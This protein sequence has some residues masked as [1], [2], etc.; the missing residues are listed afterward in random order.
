[1]SRCAVATP[2]EPADVPGRPTGVRLAPVLLLVMTTACGVGP[3]TEQA[4]RS[5]VTPAAANEG[6]GALPCPP[7]SAVGP[8]SAIID[9][10][11]FV[12][13][14]GVMYESSSNGKLPAT[15]EIGPAFAT[16]C[17]TVSTLDGTVEPQDGDAAYLPAGTELHE[18]IGHDRRT[19][20]AAESDG[21]MVAFEA[22]HNPKAN[23]GRE[24]LD[25]SS[26]LAHVRILDGVNGTD[27]VGELT[28]AMA[29]ADLAERIMA[30]KVDQ[31]GTYPHEDPDRWFV[32]LTTGDGLTTRRAFWRSTGELWRGI[33]LDADAVSL[34]EGAARPA[35]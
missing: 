24:L 9:Y 34:L 12:Q 29:L 22:H 21:R 33:L 2:R 20:L 27:P 5:D 8:T 23:V 18:L 6:G 7:P 4:A 10:V 35:R 32:E 26:G 1:M 25:L 30:A 19:V 28:D 14:H 13:V 15:V 16:V 17:R 31:A 11:D 3:P